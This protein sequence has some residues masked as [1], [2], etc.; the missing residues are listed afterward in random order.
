MV[1]GYGDI[2][3]SIFD[4]KRHSVG[5]FVRYGKCE[6]KVRYSSNCSGALGFGRVF[7]ISGPW[8]STDNN[9]Q[10]NNTHTGVL[11]I[12]V[13]ELYAGNLHSSRPRKVPP[14]MPL[15]LNLDVM[16]RIEIDS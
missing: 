3:K 6:S 8:D 7:V 13:D 12:C 1:T 9:F 16:P 4:E 11:V 10:L 2:S 14:D 15:A 5:T